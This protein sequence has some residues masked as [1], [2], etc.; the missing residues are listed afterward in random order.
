[1]RVILFD[2]D[3]TLLWSDG[4]GRRAMEGALVEVFGT[5]GPASYRYDGKTDPQIARELMLLE[6]VPVDR[7]ERDLPAVLESYVWRLR[8]AVQDESSRPH[9]FGGVL[10]LMDALEARSDVMV[11]LLTGNIHTGARIKLSAAGL[12]PDRFVFGAYGSDHHHRPALPAIA[13]ERAS[14]H[15]G[16]DIR[17]S[18][19]LIVGDTP[20]DVYCGQGIG[21]RSMAVAT[22]RYSRQ[23]LAACGPASLFDDLSD[24]DAVLQAMYAVTSDDADLVASRA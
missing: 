20:A 17:A 21:A 1:M 24:T 14:A 11:G 4:A 15:S 13:R 19:M 3:G 12:N 8:E 9:L 7:V 18:R 23:E 22:G 10:D 2:I 16:R 5:S 6:G